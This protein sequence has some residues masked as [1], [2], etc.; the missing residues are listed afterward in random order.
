MAAIALRYGLTLST[1]K[2]ARD[3]LKKCL[4]GLAP[5]P[6]DPSI[7]LR[8]KILMTKAGHQKTLSF[9]MIDVFCFNEE[10]LQKCLRETRSILL[11][12]SSS[13]WLTFLR[14]VVILKLRAFPSLVMPPS[15]KLDLATDG[16]SSLGEEFYSL[17]DI[18]KQKFNAAERILPWAIY[19]CLARLVDLSFSL[20][21]IKAFDGARC[22][23]TTLHIDLD[24]A[25]GS[26]ES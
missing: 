26:K 22:S 14:L 11:S 2:I 25:A 18:I 6:L 16:F 3:G 10:L 5:R 21:W 13:S 9:E 20:A 8:P 17:V 24:V 12:V 1:L 4:I 19:S 15:C 7:L 23:I